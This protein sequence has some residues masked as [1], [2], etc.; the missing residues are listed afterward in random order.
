MAKSDVKVML[1][2]NVAKLG[3]LGDLVS[4]APGYARNFLLPQSLAVPATPGIVKEVERRR[5]KERQRLIA[6]RQEAES[7]RTA[8]G[9]I[10]GFM[11]KK[12]VGENDSIFGTV[13]DREVADLIKAKAMLEIDRREITVPEIKKLGSYE[14]QIRLHAEV[15]A[16]IKLQVVAE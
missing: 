16:V 6:I 11:I 5:E 4:V 1:T 9:V 2:K 12:P 14:V 15:T 8:L 7:R 13:T 10:G 3:K